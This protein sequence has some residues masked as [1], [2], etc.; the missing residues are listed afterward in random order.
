M[1][2]HGSLDVGSS[3]RMK[4]RQSRR[5]IMAELFLNSLVANPH[6]LLGECQDS[7]KITKFWY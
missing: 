6:P 4:T 2:L 5:V 7:S 1:L 3:A